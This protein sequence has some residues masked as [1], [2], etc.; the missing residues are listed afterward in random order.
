MAPLAG[1]TDI[2]MKQS[3]IPLNHFDSNAQE[4]WRRILYYAPSVRQSDGYGLVDTEGFYLAADGKKNPQSELD[5]TLE[6]MNTSSISLG[7]RHP[8]CLFPARRKWLETYARSAVKIPEVKCTAF[9]SWY[10]QHQYRAV[11]MVFSSFYANN[12]SSLFGHTFI[13]LHKRPVPGVAP[14]A[15]L[16]DAVN[17]A[18]N[19][20]T[21][22]AII[23]TFKGLGGGFPGTFSLMPYYN[24]VQE[25]NNAES[26]DLWEYELNF[27]D[28]EVDWLTRALWDVGPHAIDYFYF[29]EN[30]S[31]IMLT[32]LAMANPKL[33]L[34]QD[35]HFWAIPLDTVREIRREPELIRTIAKRP[36]SLSRFLDQWRLLNPAEQRLVENLLD[37]EQ[38]SDAVKPLE[39]LGKDREALVIDTTLEAVDYLDALHS[40]KRSEHYE[41]LRSKLLLRRASLGPLTLPKPPTDTAYPDLSHPSNRLGFGLGSRREVP[42][43]SL[44]WR[45]ALHDW[46]DPAE[47]FSRG[48]AIG[49]FNL[50]LRVF[51]SKRRPSFVLESLRLLEI[52]ANTA[53]LPRL[54]RKPS[55]HLLLETKVWRS[56]DP[57]EESRKTFHDHVQHF[58]FGLGESLPVTNSLSFDAQA[59]AGLQSEQPERH[60]GI[61]FEMGARFSAYYYQGL[62]HLSLHIR[63]LRYVVLKDRPYDV[64]QSELSY[65]Y[66]FSRFSEV[67]LTGN[68]R[69]RHQEGTLQWLWY[70]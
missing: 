27:N 26:R 64:I 66:A 6:A 32:W 13:R 31:A 7:D 8:A 40:Q 65:S 18:A 24:K 1:A 4:H 49:F 22:N 61:S 25:Y 38:K 36:S 10:E 11:S 42:F 34:G 58:E 33:R 57:K 56:D 69:A 37:T 21:D 67:R 9:T 19:P 35:L 44:Q 46:S 45:P 50:D 14:A 23:Y 30:C 17:F 59:I 16:D 47:N 28:D 52:E 48:L 3:K 29:D 63:A 51:S 68:S 60:H 12:P 5:A 53:H 62:H 43:V 41:A 70:F 15:L 20:D 2:A 55:W 54:A 39:P